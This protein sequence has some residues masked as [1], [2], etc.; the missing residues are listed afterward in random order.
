MMSTDVTE[1]KETPLSVA[2]RV[3]TKEAHRDAERS[4]FVKY[5]CLCSKVLNPTSV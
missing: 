2:L 4:A 3:G 1:T 5:V